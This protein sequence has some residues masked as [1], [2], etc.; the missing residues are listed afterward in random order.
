MSSG[1]PIQNGLNTAAGASV[2]S[3]VVL[4]LYDW[5]VLGISNRF[6]WQCSTKNVLLPFFKKHLSKKHLDVGVGTGFYLSHAGLTESNQVT[7]FDL[8]ANSLRV[9]AG[10]VKRA[11]VR[12]VAGDVMQASCEL[13]ERDY[14]SISLFYLLHC[15]PG[16]MGDKEAAILNLS[17]YLSRNGVLY[18]A[19]VLGDE[20]D[21]NRLGR[22]LM[23][24][25][26]RRGLFSNRM[27]SIDSLRCLLRRHFESVQVWQHN[28]VALFVT[29]DPVMAEI[30]V[31]SPERS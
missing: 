1:E 12:V 13:Q 2:Y 20:V 19:T 31:P 4:K 29:R 8:N 9:A 22:L 5:W 15:L 21:H 6:A 26:N 28:K 17:R 23:K 11:E 10:R 25:Y 7:L 16:T 3:P 24:I 18:G 30:D 14:D 27:D